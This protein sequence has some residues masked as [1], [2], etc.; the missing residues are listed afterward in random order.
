MPEKESSIINLPF[1]LPE[2]LRCHEGYIIERAQ[3]IATDPSQEVGFDAAARIVASDVNRQVGQMFA[4][5]RIAT[6]PI[7]L[8]YKLRGQSE[9]WNP[10][11]SFNPWE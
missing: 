10:P 9:V 11:S 2:H 8:P 4:L 5:A 1:V 3:A 6:N 7:S